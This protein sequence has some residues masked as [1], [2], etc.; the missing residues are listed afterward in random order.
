[1]A[2]APK[3]QDLSYDAAFPHILFIVV[4]TVVILVSIIMASNF[5]FLAAQRTMDRSANVGATWGV[6]A[7][8]FGVAIG[9]CIACTYAS[10]ALV[11]KQP[12]FNSDDGPQRKFDPT[13]D[14]TTPFTMLQLE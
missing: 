4:S 14:L 5:M 6:A 8:I 7:I 12:F 3:R 11:I 1:M 9:L 2:A 13:K 10:K